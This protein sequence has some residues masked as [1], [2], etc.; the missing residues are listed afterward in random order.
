MRNIRRALRIAQ[1]ADDLVMQTP[2]AK[3][4]RSIGKAVHEWLEPSTRERPPQRLIDLLGMLGEID[5]T[6][7]SNLHPSGNEMR[8]EVE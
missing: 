1:E 7:S 2:Y 3:I 5:G 8:F 6:E 4:C